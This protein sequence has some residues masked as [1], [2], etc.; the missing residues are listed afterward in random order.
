MQ[1][2]PGN[3]VMW[4]GIVGTMMPLVIS[5]IV[6][7]P[8]GD[9]VK[10]VVAFLACL[11]AGTGTAYFAGNLEGRDVVTNVLVVY[12]LAIGTYY[13]FWKPTGVAPRLRDATT[14]HKEV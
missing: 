9:R 10:S 14:V 2:I 3:D 13:G 5:V 7:T 12:T 11:V 6:Q 1:D 8:W 4:A